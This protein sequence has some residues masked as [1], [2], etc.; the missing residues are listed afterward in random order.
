MITFTEEGKTKKIFR[1]TGVYEPGKNPPYV[2]LI[3]LNADIPLPCSG[4]ITMNGQPTNL[5][6]SVPD[7][8]VIDFKKLPHSPG[9]CSWCG[10]TYPQT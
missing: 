4:Q 5:Y 6:M 9:Y 7:G 8:A 2:A 10:N 1:T 3:L